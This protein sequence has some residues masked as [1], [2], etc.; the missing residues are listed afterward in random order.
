MFSAKRCT[1]SVALLC[2]LLRKALLIALS[3]CSGFPLCILLYLDNI[4]VSLK[5][6]TNKGVDCFV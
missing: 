4:G 1:V 5:N 3:A 2:I 6:I